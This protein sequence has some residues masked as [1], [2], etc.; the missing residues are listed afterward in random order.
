MIIERLKK[1]RQGHVNEEADEGWRLEKQLWLLTA[2]Q[3]QSLSKSVTPHPVPALSSLTS[4]G[5][6]LELYGD[7]G[8][9]RTQIIE[10]RR[11]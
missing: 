11:S 8:K 1:E 9:L 4:K 3:L 6:F 5:K 7:L 10:I 2:F